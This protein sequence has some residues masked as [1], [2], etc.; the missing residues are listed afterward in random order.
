MK[1]SLFETL[2]KNVTV[3]RKKQKNINYENSEINNSSFESEGINEFQKTKKFNLRNN[4]KFMKLLQNSNND[5]N[6]FCEKIQENNDSKK[7]GK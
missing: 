3:T 5:K 7:E 4:P 1:S 6:F 2:P